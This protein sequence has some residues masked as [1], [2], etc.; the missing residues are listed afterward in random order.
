MY[1]EPQ[2]PVPFQPKIVTGNYYYCP[3]ID[4][5]SQQMFG[6]YLVAFPIWFASE[7]TWTRIGF[8]LTVADAGKVA[9]LGLYAN[10]SNNQPGALIADFGTV[11]LTST[12]DLEITISQKLKKNTVYWLAFTANTDTSSPSAQCT[13]MTYYGSGLRGNGS[14]ILGSTV[15]IDSNSPL[16]VPGIGYA[17]AYAALPDPFGTPDGC[18]DSPAIWLRKT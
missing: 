5:N 16:G 3:N 6:D 1:S 11:S 4:I 15:S 9:R 14:W 7:E 10:G 12:G 13:S 18:Y 8:R 2:V 17:R